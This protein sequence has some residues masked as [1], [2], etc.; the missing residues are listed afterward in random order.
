MGI[1]HRV[2]YK[3]IVV[4]CSKCNEDLAVSFEYKKDHGTET[5]TFY[6]CNCG[7]TRVTSH[8]YHT[9]KDREYD[10]LKQKEVDAVV[11]GLSSMLN[12]FN[13][14]KVDMFVQGMAREHRTLQQSFTGLCVAWMKELARMEECNC[15]DGRN[16]AS[17]KLAKEIFAKVENTYLPMV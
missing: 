16:E 3:T 1:S 8:I 14:D 7:Q 11:K 9:Y 6:Q 4:T 12:S 17:V 13:T 15:Y 5:E 10:R 2:D